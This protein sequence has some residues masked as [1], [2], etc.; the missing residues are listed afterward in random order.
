M[1]VGWTKHLPNPA[2]KI[3]FENQII[4]SKPVLNRIKEIIEEQI[5]DTDK[6]ELSITQFENPNWAY[7]QAY[8][9]GFKS[10]LSILHRMVDLDS[11]RGV[12]DRGLTKLDRE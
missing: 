3:Q 2:D 6:S 8:K 12:N 10:A 11:Q 5:V 7:Q 1:F 4:G 9:N